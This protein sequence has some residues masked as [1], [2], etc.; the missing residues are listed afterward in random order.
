MAEALTEF[1]WRVPT[2]LKRSPQ[3]GKQLLRDVLHRYVPQSLMDRPKMGFGVPL[4]QWLRGP[5]RDWGE[6]LLGEQKLRSEGFLDPVPIRRKWEEHLSGQR[7]WHYYL[8]DVLMFE[9]WLEESG[10][11]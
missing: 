3:G 1:A 8:W 5:L 7:R 6:S 10:S 2:S 11:V 9:A 4:E